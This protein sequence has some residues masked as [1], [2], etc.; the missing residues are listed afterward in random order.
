MSDETPRKP[1]RP[2]SVVPVNAVAGL[3]RRIF[4]LEETHI[5]AVIE[6]IDAHIP[7]LTDDDCDAI[8]Y[9][10][11][12]AGEDEPLD[13]AYLAIR[14]C[15]CGVAIDGFYGYVHHLKDALRKEMS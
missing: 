14:T 13:P 2:V 10:V 12:S 1:L 8:T 7:S 15:A 5:L 3:Y 9:L 11:H 6:V 4:E